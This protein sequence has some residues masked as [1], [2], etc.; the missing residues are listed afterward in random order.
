[1]KKILESIPMVCL[2]CIDESKIHCIDADNYDLLITTPETIIRNIDLFLPIK[3]KTIILSKG[4]DV[5]RTGFKCVNIDSDLETFI[6]SISESIEH[7][8]DSI[9][10]NKLSSREIEV[11]V[12]LASGR[13]Q[14]EIA[15]RLCISPTT[16]ITHRK[17]ISAKLG[18]RSISGLALYAAINGY[19]KN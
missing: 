4:F 6:E 19:I 3:G 17:N 15:E 14:K 5:K 10:S 7:K 13:T 2:E 11:L 1:M 8:E 18:I 16:V 12:E 9:S